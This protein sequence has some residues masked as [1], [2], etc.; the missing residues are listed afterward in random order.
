MRR[1]VL[2]CV[3]LLIAS[4]TACYFPEPYTPPYVDPYPYSFTDSSKPIYPQ[5]QYGARLFVA[6]SRELWRYEH[7]VG[8]Q[9]PAD[10]C[11]W[12]RGDCDDFAVMVAFYLQEHFRY[13]TFILQLSSKVS[14]RSGHACAFVRQTSGV[15]EVP[16]SCSYPY[17]HPDGI[18]YYPVDFGE[19]PGWTWDEYDIDWEYRRNSSGQ[20]IAYFMFE[21]YDMSG[22]AYLSE[23]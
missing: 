11:R 23:D 8:V 13:D 3:L 5:S 2:L 4:L 18:D 21:W 9:H 17:I 12:M 20:T 14:Y 19:C 16:S 7:N 10:S 22:N 6:D 1:A 15:A